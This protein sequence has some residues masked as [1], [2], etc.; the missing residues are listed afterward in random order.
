MI[1]KIMY[2]LIYEYFAAALC[3]LDKGYILTPD[4]RCICPPNTALNEND[5]CIH[6]PITKGLKIDER[7]HCV[8]ALERGLIIDERGNCIC[9]IEFG[10]RLD[11]KGNCIPKTGP[12]CE[13]DNQCPDHK[14][15]NPE[16]KTCDDPCL[17]K[18]CGTNAFCNA[19]NHIAV[20]QCSSGYSGNPEI[21][22]SKY[23]FYI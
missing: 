11:F 23:K 6:C 17:K 3:R 14:Y 9:P 18:R 7:G 21:Y 10:Y 13:T 1:I 20:C 5:E 22:C 2:L 12:E 16:M 8:C 19:T 4:G 15:C